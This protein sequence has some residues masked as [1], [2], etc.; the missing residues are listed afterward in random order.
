M[1][2]LE[3]AGDII[4]PMALIHPDRKNEHPL[5]PKEVGELIGVTVL[6]LHEW[7]KLGVGPPF[8]QPIKRGTVTYYREDIVEWMDRGKSAN[9]SS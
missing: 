2:I 8:Y 4:D 6:T 9:S 7:R 5:T 3:N 1:L